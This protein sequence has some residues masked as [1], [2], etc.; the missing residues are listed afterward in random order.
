MGK[1]KTT[2]IGKACE[3]VLERLRARP[4]G[5]WTSGELDEATGLKGAT[6][7]LVEL[8]RMGLALRGERRRC[9]VTGRSAMAWRWSGVDVGQ[10][11]PLKKQR[12][13]QG[14]SHAPQSC[15]HCRALY[16]QG[17][18]AGRASAGGTVKVHAH[19]GTSRVVSDAAHAS[20]RLR[21]I[22]ECGLYAGD[23]VTRDWSQVTCVRCLSTREFRNRAQLRLVFPGCQA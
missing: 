6:K 1:R 8:Q 13:P 10:H 19:S 12:K 22:S 15:H 21:P 3:Q 11:E 9:T 17:F 7:R 5:T 16:L 4:S 14:H 2:G 20:G 18:L 23:S